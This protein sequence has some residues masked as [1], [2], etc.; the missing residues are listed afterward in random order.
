MRFIVFIDLLATLVQPASLIYIVYLIFLQA[1]YK[2]LLT[3]I[4]LV[5]LCLIAAV[6]G[7]QIIIFLFR[8]EWQHIGWMIFYLL[9][10]P[11]FGCKFV[12][13]STFD[14]DTKTTD[15]VYIPLY[16]FWHFD[17]FSWGNT[18]VIV[19][20]KGK[21]VLETKASI[22]PVFFLISFFLL[23]LLLMNHLW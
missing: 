23:I 18:R 13:Y 16:S 10:T 9:A 17:D 11:V 20:E 4:P 15:I 21:K 5:S 19:G 1:F 2:D 14:F 7:F 8:A 12:F 22:E 3:V 6:Y